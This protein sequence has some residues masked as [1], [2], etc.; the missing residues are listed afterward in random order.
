MEPLIVLLIAFVVAVIV[1]KTIHGGYKMALSG[2]IAISLMLL[3][4]AMG[5]FAF[6]EGMT[7]MLPDFLPFKKGIVYLTGVI[8]IMA[9]IGLLI[10]HLSR[11]T[12]WLLILFFVLIL[13]ANVYAA[14]NQVDIQ[15]ATYSGDGLAYLWFRIPLQILFILWI[16]LSSIRNN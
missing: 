14:I 5:H 16:Y 10:P 12:G 4:T 15:T 6:T 8:E 3:F 7:M 11:L 9:A 13:P 1:F 2:R